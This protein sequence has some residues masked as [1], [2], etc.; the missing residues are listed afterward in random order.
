MAQ[1]TYPYP[2]VAAA[3]P[4]PHAGW[5]SG[6]GISAEIALGQRAAKLNMND[7]WLSVLTNVST[8][9]LRDRVFEVVAALNALHAQLAASEK[10]AM[11]QCS[12]HVNTVKAANGVTASFTTL[13]RDL[14]VAK[15]NGDM[16]IK[17]LATYKRDYCECRGGLC[18][19][20]CGCNKG[21]KECSDRCGC[22]GACKENAKAKAK[23]AREERALNKRFKELNEPTPKKR[24]R[25]SRVVADPEPDDADEPAE[26]DDADPN[27]SPD[28]S[29]SDSDDETVQEPVAAPKPKDKPKAKPKELVYAGNGGASSF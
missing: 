17:H 18:G 19:K 23:E 3:P 14:T 13:V 6:L 2:A 25:V 5:I 15:R 21:K 16:E 11:L 8:Q 9:Q 4:P 29:G 10:H 26:D 28:A 24:K 7:F 27:Y 12:H 20:A 1:P 22:F